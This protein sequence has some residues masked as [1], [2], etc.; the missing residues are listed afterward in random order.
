M[1]RGKI[2]SALRDAV[3]SALPVNEVRRLVDEEFALANGHRGGQKEK[4]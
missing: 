4:N 2:R 3:A 1:V